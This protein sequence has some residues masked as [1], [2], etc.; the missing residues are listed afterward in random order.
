VDPSTVDWSSCRP[1]NLDPICIYRI[2]SIPMEDGSFILKDTP[3]DCEYLGLIILICT[4]KTTIIF[5]FYQ[6]L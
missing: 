4:Y 1:W 5:S 6:I 3:V 2:E